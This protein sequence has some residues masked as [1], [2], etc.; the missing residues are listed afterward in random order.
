MLINKAQAYAVGDLVTYKLVNGDEIV[1]EITELGE[2]S[3]RLSRPCTVVPSGQGIGLIQALFTADLS[4]DVWLH[5]DK[6][7]LHAPTTEALRAHY[8]KTTTG[9]ETI[10]RQGIIT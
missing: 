7:M 10:P 4:K 8:I 3:W 2:R 5:E 1:A 9:I 6:V